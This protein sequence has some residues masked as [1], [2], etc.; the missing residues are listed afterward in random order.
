MKKIFLL[1]VFLFSFCF[2]NFSYSAA[3][4]VN[5]IG[6]PWCVDTQIMKPGTPN[7]SNNIWATFMSKIIGEFIQIVAV[8]AVFALIFSWILYLLSAWEEE[9]A[10]KAKKW[11]IWSLVWVLLSISSWG[12]INFLNN[13]KINNS[14]TSWT[15]PSSSSTTINYIVDWNLYETR[16]SYWDYPSLPSWYTKW[17][18]VNTNEF[19]AIK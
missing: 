10:N 13:V 6:L 18:Q 16:E 14:W 17:E 15:L 2:V 19:N 11:I 7:I 3:P 12:I 5:C 4:E 1:L 8:F 9:K